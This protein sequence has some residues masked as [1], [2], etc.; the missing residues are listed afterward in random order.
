MKTL[1]STRALASLFLFI[2]ASCGGN[3]VT[4]HSKDE[5]ANDAALRLV[6]IT[7]TPSPKVVFRTFQAGLDDNMRMVI[8]FPKSKLPSFW[9]SS[10]WNAAERKEIF[11]HK[12]EATILDQPNLSDGSEPDWESWKRSNHGIASWVRLP[13]ARLANV[14]VA[15]DQD[16][17]DAVAYIF[18]NE[19]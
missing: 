10:P 2:F 4:I 12:P 13:N 11:P 7:T 3:F 18:W 15:L 16:A 5:P 17:N 6:G 9:S 19:T 14:F 8:R 1:M